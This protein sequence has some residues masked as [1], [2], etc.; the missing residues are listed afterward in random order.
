M[1]KGEVV[2]VLHNGQKAYAV[3]NG[4]EGSD[5]VVRLMFQA[6]LIAKTV[7]PEDCRTPHFS[8]NGPLA[9]FLRQAVGVPL[10]KEPLRIN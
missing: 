6:E 8:Q 1:R 10:D 2:K 5:V 3:V 9:S 7:A 4:L